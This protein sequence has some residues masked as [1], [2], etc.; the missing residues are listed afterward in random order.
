MKEALYYCVGRQGKA[1]YQTFPA[2]ILSLSLH[3]LL[4]PFA[5]LRLVAP[6]LNLNS[7]CMLTRRNSEFPPS[8]N[9]RENCSRLKKKTT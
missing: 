5:L 6:D 3:F 8:Q 9:L 4:E 1:I 7:D 2:P